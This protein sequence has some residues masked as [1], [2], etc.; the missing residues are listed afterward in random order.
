M[1]WG[2]HMSNFHKVT[3]YGSKICDSTM[4]GVTGDTAIASCDIMYIQD[5]MSKIIRKIDHIDS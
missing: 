3:Q 4:T 5:N 1:T 2:S